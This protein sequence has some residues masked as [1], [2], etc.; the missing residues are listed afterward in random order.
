ML[1]SELISGSPTTTFPASPFRF[2]RPS[3]LG[4]AEESTW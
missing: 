4:M 3:L 1:V 2:D